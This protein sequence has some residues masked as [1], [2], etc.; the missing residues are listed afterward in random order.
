MR[1]NNFVDTRLAYLELVISNYK[2]AVLGIQGSS[3]VT[4][5]QRH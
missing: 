5:L 2:Q 1:L 4:Y 3:E